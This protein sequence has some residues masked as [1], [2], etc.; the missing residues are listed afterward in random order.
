MATLLETKLD[1]ISHEE[2]GTLIKQGW[3]YKGLCLYQKVDKKTDRHFKPIGP[4][5]LI[6][7]KGAT[8]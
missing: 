4:I 2:L 5:R 7:P 1:N 8:Q 6:A 3:R